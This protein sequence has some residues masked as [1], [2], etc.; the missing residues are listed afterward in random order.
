[1]FVV[2]AGMMFGA[3]ISIGTWLFWNQLPVTL[4]NILSGTFFTGLALYATY[5]PEQPAAVESVE[6]ATLAV[7]RQAV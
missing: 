2:P 4:G 6:P 5:R 1:M 3:P 7:E